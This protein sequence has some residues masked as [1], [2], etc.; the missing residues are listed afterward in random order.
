MKASSRHACLCL[1]WVLH[2]FATFPAQAAE[3]P[4]ACSLQQAGPSCETGQPAGMSKSSGVSQE[5]GNPINLITGNKVQREVDMAPLPGL[6]GL[7]LVRHYNSY[8]AAPGMPLSGAG[9]GWQFSYDTRL[10]PVGDSLQILQADGTRLRFSRTAWSSTL[11][12]APDP[13]HGQVRII[14]QGRQQ[15]YHWRWPNGRELAFD[16]N[17]RLTHIFAP[18]GEWLGIERDNAGRLRKV[19]D[20]Q[21]RSMLFHYPDRKALKAGTYPGIQSVDTPVGRFLYAYG[22]PESGSAAPEPARRTNLTAVHLPTSYDPDKPR[23]TFAL[24]DTPTTTSVSTIRRIY[25]YEDP[26]FPSLLTGI[27]VEGTGNDGRALRERIATW[28]YDG[29]GLAVLSVRGEPAGKDPHGKPLPGTGIEQ[30]SIDRSTP[31]LVRL[32]NS[33]GQVT[34]YRHAIVAGDRRLLE[35]RGPGCASCGDTDQRYSYDSK[36]R[37]QEVT[38]LDAAGKPL[39]GRRLWM[40]ALGRI[41]GVSVVDYQQGKAVGRR[42]VLRQQYAHPG[43]E[44]AWPASRIAQ[45]SYGPLLVARDSVVPGKERQWRFEYNQHQQ[46]VSL[47][48][49]GF[50]P[51]DGSEM[52]R[53]THY[54]YQSIHGRSVLVEIDGPLP[55]GPTATPADSDITRYEWDATGSQVVAV[56]VPGGGRTVLEHDPHTGRV[57]RMVREDGQ[58]I[59]LRHDSSGRIIEMTATGPGWQQPLVRSMLFDARGRQTGSGAGIPGQPDWQPELLAAFDTAGRPAWTATATGIAMQWRY[60]TENHLQQT[61]TLSNRIHRTWQYRHDERGRIIEAIDPAGASLR[62]GY[63]EDGMAQSASPSASMTNKPAGRVVHV[64]DDFGRRVAS[65]SPD[66]GKTRYVHDEA[67]RLIASTDAAG[68]R[69]VYAYDISGRILRQDIWPAGAAQAD[70]TR[71]Q[72]QGRRLVALLHPIQEERYLHDE[73]G[74]LIR[75]TTLRHGPVQGGATLVTQTRYS[76]DSRGRLDSI[77]LPDGSLIRYLR[78]GQG[79]VTAMQRSRIQTDWLRWLLPAQVIARDIERDLVGIARYVTGNGI[80]AR[81]QR[82]REGMLARI[83]HRPADDPPALQGKTAATRL[84]GALRLPPDLQALYDDRLLWDVRGNLLHRRTE[85]KGW[86]AVASSYAY[87]HANRLIVATQP[88]AA[89][90][91]FHDAAGNRLL[92]QQGIASQSEVKAGT[93][94]SRYQPGSN[95]WLGDMVDGK[96]WPPYRYDANGQLVDAGDR[97]YGWDAL[98]RLMTVQRGDGSE[99]ARYVYNHRGER[100]ASIAGGGSNSGSSGNSNSGNG[101]NGNSV[102][103]FLYED[104]KLQAETDQQGRIL[105]QY[106]WLG[107]QPLAVIDSPA[108]RVP[109]GAGALSQ[110]MRDIATVL[111]AWLGNDDEISWL[112]PDHLGAVALAT[113]AAGAAIWQASYSPYGA[114]TIRAAQRPGHPAFTWNLRLPGQYWDAATG[115]HYNRHR[116][117]GPQSGRYLTPDPLGMPDGPNSYVYVKNNP[118]RYVDPEGLVLFAFDGTGNAAE[119]LAGDTISN[120]RKFWSAYDEKAN[121]KGYYITGIGT[122]DKDMPVKGNMANGKGFDER[123]DLGFKFLDDYIR[124]EYV[125]GK[126][127][128]IDVVGFSRGAA[129]AR[130]WMNQ[131]IEKM[132]QSRYTSKEGKSACLSLRFM[133]LW[134]TVPHLGYFNGDEARYDFSIDPSMPYVAHAV[135]LNEHRGVG[136][137]FDGVSILPAP[138]T[139][140][141]GNR[142]EIG[143]IGSHAD[144]GGGYGTGDLSDVA[145]MWMIEQAKR[146]GVAFLNERIKDNEW[147]IVS[148]PIIHD[149]SSNKLD[150][151]IFSPS[152]DR[153]FSYGN[154][155]S[156]KQ[157][158]AVVGG[159][160]TAWARSQVNYYSTWCGPL[161]SP[162]VGLVDMQK[163]NDWLVG[164]GIN[165][166]YAPQSST[167]RCE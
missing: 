37:L 107:D 162:A 145:L 139:T 28:G 58:S 48:E 12:T 40:D 25:H 146:Q 136:I 50:N 63:P 36:G 14:R 114:A 121:G 86:Q 83:V 16:S 18:S 53:T 115:L 35:V 122:T 126:A 24:G 140:S 52:V 159:N 108:G 19:S 66:S 148:S 64:T 56:S 79:Q 95:R 105:R 153:D 5:A 41:Y 167:Q 11:C 165:I 33:L 21:G 84:P 113:N 132:T 131:L 147:N 134:D 7:E 27:T 85:G 69:A 39:E 166:S 42:L 143:F 149:K 60:N 91:Y 90:R 157:A 45:Q 26:R 92:S 13:A 71:W 97:R 3:E 163:Y 130:V 87:D 62:P 155:T 4:P 78:N 61:S 29:N 2:A 154:G 124:D 117:Y 43:P 67:D 100:I 59:A 74:L 8:H 34:V 30:I 110:A 22:A 44:Q 104:G 94:V 23:P 137:S 80:E 109:A 102:V 158:K 10:Y 73:R 152:G 82:S 127:I 17:G 93:A 119:P 6:L 47:T 135:A 51:L 81:Y 55:N 125:P 116:Y 120:V 103:G 96:A 150:P 72:Y 98:G 112:H 65:I 118:L 99:V 76:H 9:R 101:N 38:R 46:P 1:L 32:T 144:I 156:V 161:E 89:S 70:T 123:V 88:G 68:N 106:L 49:R 133:G 141:G 128:D 31:G 20:P 151:P 54:R 142:I 57:T 77:S 15:H 75:K 164:Q 129:E 111:R 138:A 160:D